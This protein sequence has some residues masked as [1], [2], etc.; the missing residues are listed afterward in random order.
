MH[1]AALLALALAPSPDELVV[2]DPDGEPRAGTPVWIL[3]EGAVGGWM[4][5]R[6]AVAADRWL[7][8]REIDAW[9]DENGRVAL[10]DSARPLLCV[11]SDGELRGS[12]WVTS[13]ADEAVGLRLALAPR[14]VVEVRDVEGRPI[15]DAL[16]ALEAW[17]GGFPLVA[18]PAGRTDGEGRAEVR[19]FA[20]WLRSTGVVDWSVVLAD[21]FVPTRIGVAYRPD[22]PPSTPLVLETPPLGSVRLCFVEEG[23]APRAPDASVEVSSSG[24]SRAPRWIDEPGPDLR[25]GHV[26]L[27]TTLVVTLYGELGPSEPTHV[28]GPSEPA[29]E[30]VA[31]IVVRSPRAQQPTLGTG[32]ILL[33]GRALDPD[34][35]PLAGEELEIELA[36]AET[37][38]RLPLQTDAEGRFQHVIGTANGSPTAPIEGR[39]VLTRSDRRG[40]QAELR[41]ETLPQNGIVELGA[42]RF[43]RLPGIVAGRVVDAEHAPVAGARIELA[44]IAPTARVLHDPGITSFAS[45]RFEVLRYE[46]RMIGVQPELQV[47]AVSTDAGLSR[48]TA[49]ERGRTDVVLRLEPPAW[50]E[51]ELALPSG[52]EPSDVRLEVVEQGAAPAGSD[53]AASPSDDGRFRVGPVSPGPADLY[54]WLDP[55]HGSD[56][57]LVAV[58]AIA[59]GGAA[60]SRLAPLDVRGALRAYELHV[61][62]PD[63]SP[64]ASPRLVYEHL[65]RAV[66]VPYVGSAGRRAFRL[67]AP[68][69]P[70]VVRIDAS[71][72]RSKSAPLEPGVTSVRLEPGLRVRVVVSNPPELGE[73]GLLAVTLTSKAR[74]P[75]PHVE[76]DLSSSGTAVATLPMPGSWQLMFQRRDRV[77]TGNGST[78]WLGAA[79]WHFRPTIEVADVADEQSFTIELDAQTRAKLEQSARR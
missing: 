67:V 54:V 16:V 55:R 9:S 69:P 4:V 73:H 28:V 78:E 68:P 59:A 46:S 33:A 13:R 23:G 39:L 24:L 38:G 10:P 61:L 62:A 32:E 51:G 37:W 21:A 14:F 36:W 34:G 66:F 79:A 41:I 74:H 53:A 11:A 3:D 44:E 18:Q 22:P 43:A 35:R 71:G 65:G 5:E 12:V 45:G 29:E 8:E 30:V 48:W 6:P 50:I 26:A 15:A 31:S 1:V 60:D 40:L 76:L 57:G 63:G 7:A 75:L 42:V 20:P 58:R 52:V 56:V 77:P 49:F 47:R 17:S 25:L 2:L 19:Q 70:L 64:A 27:G 72:M